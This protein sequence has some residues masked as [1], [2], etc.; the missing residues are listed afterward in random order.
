MQ[1][2]QELIHL[3]YSGNDEAL[4]LL[5]EYY[6][7]MVRAI[8]YSRIQYK[9]A[10]TLAYKEYL[11]LAD[12]LLVECLYRYRSDVKKDFTSLYR[13]SFKNRSL[14][15][16]EKNARKSFSYYS[17]PISLNQTIADSQGTYLSDAIPASNMDVEKIAFTNI[18]LEQIEDT[19]QKDFSEEEANIF[20]LKKDGYSNSEIAAMK[21]ISAKKVRYVLHKIK[22]CCIT[23]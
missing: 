19:L 3:F 10:D 7:P 20:H 22:K 13:Q 17:T 9:G 11:S 14:D 16:L 6:R 4:S 12:S 5:I 21:K 15:L 18:L 8:T 1:N 2:V 23:D